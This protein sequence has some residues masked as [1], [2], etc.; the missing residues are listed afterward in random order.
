MASTENFMITTVSEMWDHIRGQEEPEEP[1]FASELD[2]LDWLW[3]QPSKPDRLRFA[4]AAEVAKYRHAILK[5]V[6]Q[7]KEHDM[8]AVLDRARERIRNANIIS[9]VPK[10]I[11][12]D[13]S[14]LKP[15]HARSPGAQSPNGFRRRF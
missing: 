8:A 15:D 11:E 4:A 1:A 13:A 12:H 2:F 3:K 6:A 7:V 10:A 9:L 14:E 5:A